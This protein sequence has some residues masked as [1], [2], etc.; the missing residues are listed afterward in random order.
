MKKK[1][2]KSETVPV[3]IPVPLNASLEITTYERPQE[4][5]FGEKFASAAAAIKSSSTVAADTLREQLTAFLSTMD[6]VVKGLPA[7]IGEFRL[8]T[9][10]LKVEVSAKGTVSLLGTGGELSGT[11]GLTFTL[12]RQK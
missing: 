8:E 3:S 4:R 11:G 1:T 9:V 7:K 2:T 12:Q 6:T 10:E 5:G